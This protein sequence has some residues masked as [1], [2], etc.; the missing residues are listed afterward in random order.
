M[1]LNVR[2]IPTRSYSNEMSERHRT[3]AL[4][5]PLGLA[6]R[7]LW[8]TMEEKEMIKLEDMFLIHHKDCDF[9]KERD[10]LKALNTQCHDECEWFDVMAEIFPCNCKFKWHRWFVE[11]TARPSDFPNESKGIW[12]HYY[13]YDK[14]ALTLRSAWHKGDRQMWKLHDLFQEKPEEKPDK[15]TW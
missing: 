10:L 11:I 4:R 3:L 12:T 9:L 7:N 13:M 14:R 1:V 5:K 15:E 2:S 8:T 6:V